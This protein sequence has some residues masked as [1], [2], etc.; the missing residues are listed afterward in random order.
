MDVLI[1]L[2]VH[3]LS[4][5]EHHAMIMYIILYLLNKTTGNMIP[6]LL[7]IDI[8][9]RK[10]QIDHV[11]GDVVDRHNAIYGLKMVL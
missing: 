3:I 1:H 8:S 4:I 2:S 10:H 6:F 7:P 9:Y 5:H 11:N